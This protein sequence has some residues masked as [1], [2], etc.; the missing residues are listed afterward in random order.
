MV[1]RRRKMQI[2]RIFLTVLLLGAVASMSGCL[3]AAVGAGAVGTVAYIKGDLEAVE[4]KN[5]DAVYAAT[6]KA[7]KQLRLSVTRE[8]K[9]A[10]SGIITAR[11]A[12]DKKVTIK[13]NSTAEG[14]TKI[15]VR[16]GLFGNETKSN[17][18]YQRIH[19]NL[20]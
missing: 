18:I 20:R 17:L 15:S 2:Q 1:K 6:K 13:L 9:D 19:D 7:L 4:A 3:A 11:D 14:A 10:I 8:S 5:I 16:V 12:Q